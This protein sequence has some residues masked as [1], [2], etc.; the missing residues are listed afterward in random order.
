MNLKNLLNKYNKVNLTTI[1]EINM[2]CIIQSTGSI[3]HM[4]FKTKEDIIKIYFTTTSGNG[5]TLKT[6]QNYAITICYS[7]KL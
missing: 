7:N 6:I 5:I 3:I 1:S 2:I 4:Y